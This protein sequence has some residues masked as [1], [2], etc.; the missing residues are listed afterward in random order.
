MKE[1]TRINQEGIRV[2]DLRRPRVLYEKLGFE[3]LMCP[4]SMTVMEHPSGVNLNFI[5]NA[6]DDA[7]RA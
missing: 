7:A 5:L 2:R 4:E 1:I 3:F 6:S